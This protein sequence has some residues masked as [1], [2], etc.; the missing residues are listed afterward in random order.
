MHDG[1]YFFALVRDGATVHI[2]YKAQFSGQPAAK[3]RRKRSAGDELH[4]TDEELGDLNMDDINE[5]EHRGSKRSNTG[6]GHKQ[7][8]HGCDAREGGEAQA[9]PR[10]GHWIHK[11]SHKVGAFARWLVKLHLECIVLHSIWA[12]PEYESK[13]G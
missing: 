9:E 4:G 1:L 12:R 13:E 6:R 3:G 2:N 11:N 8:M 10:R 5:G 7:G